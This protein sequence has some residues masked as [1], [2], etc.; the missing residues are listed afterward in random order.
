MQSG[1]GRWEDRETG[2][3]SLAYKGKEVCATDA[4]VVEVVLLAERKGFCQGI[5]QLVFLLIMPWS[6]SQLRFAR[7]LCALLQSSSCSLHMSAIP[8]SLHMSALSLV[9]QTACL[10]EWITI[11]ACNSRKHMMVFAADI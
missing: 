9:V 2:T 6:E 3:S 1:S 10:G 5:I 11:K 8:C 4:R 7:W